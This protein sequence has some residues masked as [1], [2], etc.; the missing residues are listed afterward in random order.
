M[1]ILLKNDTDEYFMQKCGGGQHEVDCAMLRGISL[2]LDLLQDLL[3]D[4]INIKSDF[5]VL[6]EGF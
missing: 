6:K 1:V 4:S 2:C 3:L 5:C